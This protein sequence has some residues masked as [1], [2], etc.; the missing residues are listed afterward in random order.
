[1]AASGRYTSSWF[2]RLGQY[3]FYVNFTGGADSR[4]F[5]V[6]VADNYRVGIYNTDTHQVTVT[7]NITI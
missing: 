5:V 3:I 2:N 7:G 4:T 1:M 6:N